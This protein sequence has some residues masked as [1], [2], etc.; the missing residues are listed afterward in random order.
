MPFFPSPASGR[1][2]RNGNDSSVLRKSLSH[3]TCC[4]I[5]NH[6][7]CPDQLRIKTFFLYIGRP[8]QS[9]NSRQVNFLVNFSI[10]P[11]I[12]GHFP[13]SRAKPTL[14]CPIQIPTSSLARSP[15]NHHT[16]KHLESLW[17]HRP[18]QPPSNPLLRRYGRS[19]VAATW[20]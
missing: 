20:L 1:S 14:P 15:S 3:F 16:N 17:P 11:P 19:T 9:K 10:G 7:H 4:E 5:I 13:P 8:L 6:C 18:H 12:Y 2:L